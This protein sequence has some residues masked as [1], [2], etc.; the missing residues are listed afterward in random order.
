MKGQKFD[1]ASVV[2]QNIDRPRLDLSQ[3]TL[4]E[5]VD[6]IGHTRMLAN[7]LTVRKMLGRP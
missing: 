4:M 3:D 6:L 1:Q 2:R 5:V 7:T